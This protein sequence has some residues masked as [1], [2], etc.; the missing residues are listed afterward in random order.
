[1][2]LYPQVVTWS[3]HHP[4]MELFAACRLALSQTSSTVLGGR[5]KVD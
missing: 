1:M 5:E 4:R 3:H 2:R